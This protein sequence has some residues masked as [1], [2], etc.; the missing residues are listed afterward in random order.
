M[1]FRY[2]NQ[3]KKQGEPE[4]L[5]E[6]IPAHI[7][8]LEK[9]ERLLKAEAWTSEH[10]KE[11]YSELTATVRTYLENRFDI[12][13]MEQTTRE[14]IQD[15]KHSPISESDKVY[16][17]KILREADMVK[18]AKFAPSDEDAMT[19]LQNSIDFVNRTKKDNDSIDEN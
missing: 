3:R 8:A 4:V 12:H 15:L 13:A 6:I 16:L 2:V 14:I 11:Y 5:E 18:F 1:V 7:L 10:K 17:R 19:Y 9:L